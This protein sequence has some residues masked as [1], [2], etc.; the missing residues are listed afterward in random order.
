[1][2][3]EVMESFCD[4]CDFRRGDLKM[5]REVRHRFMRFRSEKESRVG[6]VESG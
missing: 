6:E 4:S 5:D 2:K 3:S 1:M